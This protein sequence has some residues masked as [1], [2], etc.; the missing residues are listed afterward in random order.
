MKTPNPSAHESN[1]SLTEMPEEAS[2]GEHDSAL[3]PKPY[4]NPAQRRV[5]PNRVGRAAQSSSQGLPPR[6]T[7]SKGPTQLSWKVNV[8]KTPI[9]L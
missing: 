2:V 3:I 4:I 7:A 9:F 6:S 5:Q 1:L 8:R